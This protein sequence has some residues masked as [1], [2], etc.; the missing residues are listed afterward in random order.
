L[1]LYKTIHICTNVQAILIVFYRY[2]VKYIPS[3]TIR[4]P[5]K[6]FSRAGPDGMIRLPSS[7]EEAAR[8]GETFPDDEN[9]SIESPDNERHFHDEDDDIP[10]PVAN[11]KKIKVVEN[12]EDFFDVSD[13]EEEGVAVAGDGRQDEGTKAWRD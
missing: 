12:E 10:P 7:E 4:I 11:N 9:D 13:G 8:M 6:V 5:L 1:Q 3:G 2:A